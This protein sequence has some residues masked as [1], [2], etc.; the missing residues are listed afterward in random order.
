[1][2]TYRGYNLLITIQ[3][4]SNGLISFENSF[5]YW[6]SIFPINT[7]VIAPFWDDAHLYHGELRYAILTPTTNLSLCNQVNN[8]LTTST[9][10]SVSVQWILWAY[11]YDACP[12]FYWNCDFYNQVDNIIYALFYDFLIV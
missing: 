7:P 9:G 10:S 5:I 12:V 4:S 8:Y 11:W 1:M 3:I 2:Y 6:P